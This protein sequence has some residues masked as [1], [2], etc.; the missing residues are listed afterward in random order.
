MIEPLINAIAPLIVL[1]ALGGF[2]KRSLIRDDSIWVGL[3]SL[4][5]YLLMPSLLFMTISQADLTGVPWAPL[6]TS[7]YVPIWI[8]AAVALLPLLG[9]STM[10]R[11]TRSSLFQGITRFNLYISLSLGSSLFDSQTLALLGLLAGALIVL[12]NVM[13]VSVMVTLN[14]GQLDLTQTLKELAKNPL[15]IACLAGALASPLGLQPPTFLAITLERLG[16]TALPL[17]LLAIG[18][19]LSLAKF[20]QN[21]PLNTYS[22]VLQLVV[23]PAL[24][25]G[26]VVLLDLDLTLGLVV[27][28][29]LATPT[30]PSSY[31]L[32]RK[33]GGDAQSMAS[34]IVFQTVVGLGSILLML[35]LWQIVTG[36]RLA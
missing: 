20:T 13:C 26:M 1:M 9:A 12:V 27:V 33:L 15:L 35:T 16:A 24:A 31:I 23:K 2:L 3:E 34:I 30:A 19:G 29:L 10:S 17:S 32:A 7:L 4:V 11:A 36:T 18:A 5:Y 14:S 6:L 25:A 21:L 28:L 22:G 8:M